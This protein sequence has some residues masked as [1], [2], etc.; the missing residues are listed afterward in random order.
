MVDRSELS[1]VVVDSAETTHIIEIQAFIIPQV[2]ADVFCAVPSDLDPRL[3]NFQLA[4]DDCIT[5]LLFQIIEYFL[6]C[7]SKNAN[8]IVNNLDPTSGGF[9]NQTFFSHL[10]LQLDNTFQQRLGARWTTRHVDI[11][12]YDPVNTF[13]HMITVFPVRTAAI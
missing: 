4:F 12:W 5:E 1:I 13:E 8:V 7:H 11:D 9:L 2:L 3:W 10:F 6:R